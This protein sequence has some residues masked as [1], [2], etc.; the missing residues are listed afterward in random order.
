MNRYIDTHAHLDFPQFE[1]DLDQVV[2]RAGQAGV[3]SI[4]NAGTT[5]KS[6]RQA[7]ELSDL[8]PRIWASVGVHPH[9]A[10]K[11]SACW[12][13]TLERL[14]ANLKVL[15]VGETGLDYYRYLSP[16]DRQEDVFREQIRLACRLNKPL[17]I[18]SRLANAETLRILRDEPLP[19]RIGVMHC[20]SGDRKELRAFLEIGFFISI[21]GPV[22]Y[23]RAHALRDL[24]KDIPQDRLLLETDCPYLSPQTYR[25]LRNE[26]A[27]IKVI[28]DRVALG[29]NM[30]PAVLSGVIQENALRLFPELAS[31]HQ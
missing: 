20:F 3:G 2:K 28:Y 1:D 27:F 12:L 7:V 14:A 26:P 8:Y 18:H 16:P 23:P 13:N 9:Y 30:K 31:R 21:A 5:E 25:G 17:L 19:G 4:I 15:A 29:L 10:E 22:T 24:L 11:V 6:S